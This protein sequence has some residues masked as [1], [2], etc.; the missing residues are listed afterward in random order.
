MKSGL[1][2]RSSL[3]SSIT[4]TREGIGA[5]GAGLLVVVDVGVVARVAQEFLAAVELAADGV[6]HAVDERQVVREV[7]DHGRHV[8]HLRH[9]GEGGAALEVREDEVQGLRGVGDRE[10]EDQGAQQLGLAG[11]GR[12]HTQ[13][14]RAHALLRGLLEVEH[15]GPA[16]LPEPDRHPQPLGQRP[17]P[18]G[19]FGV[20]GGRV[21]EVQQI[22]ELQ[23]GEQRLVVVP[24]GRHPQRRQLPRERLGGLV[25]EGVGS[26]LVDVSV[27][28]LQM[29]RRRLYDDGEL[30]AD[31]GRFAGDDVDE[32]HALQA[33]GVGQDRV[34]G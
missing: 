26:P 11:A 7:G 23:V 9:A 32:R 31:R 33:L 19:A 21:T 20:D 1:A 2:V 13:S 6:A 5:R 34:G 30:A 18:P 16:V 12:A 8:R 10:A 17:R 29:Q 3:N 28:G 27:P 4:S 25:R 14:V 15:H 24:T 22:G